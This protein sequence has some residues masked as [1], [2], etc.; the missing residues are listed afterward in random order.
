MPKFYQVT[1]KSLKEQKEIQIKYLMFWMK[2]LKKI[3][4]IKKKTLMN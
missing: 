2:F 4:K 1:S 3:R